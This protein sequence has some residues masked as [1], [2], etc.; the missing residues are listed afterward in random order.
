MCDVALGV[1]TSLRQGKVMRTHQFPRIWSKVVTSAALG[2][3]AMY[4]LDPN[5]GRRRRAI[6]RDKT[7]SSLTNITH[8]A[9]VSARDLSHRVQGLRAVARRLFKGRGAADDLVLI[10]RVRAKMGRVVSHP[11]AIQIGA[12]DGRITLSGPIVP[13]EVEP[14]LDAVRSVWGVSGIDDHL[15]VYDRPESIPALQGGGRRGATRSELM[16]EEWTPA[17][18]VAAVLGGGALAVCAMRQRGLTRVALA[19]MAVGLTARGAANM[20]LMHIAG[21]TRSR[22]TIELQRTIRVAAPRDMVYD[23]W[24]D[25]ENFPRFMSHVEEVREIG[26]DRTHW[27]VRGP[28]GSLFEWDA[29]VTRCIRPE[30][31]SWR[32]VPGTVVQHAGSLHFEDAEGGTRVSIKMSY[33][34]VAGLGHPIASLLGS[35]PKQQMEDDLARMKTFIEQGVP[36][37]DATA[38]ERESG[39]KTALH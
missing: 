5:K 24:T 36:P 32:T 25:C 34:A 27:V 31:L 7:R 17:L 4:V 14:L 16:Q 10:E 3:A 9:Q 30:V 33:N 29:V 22:R 21:F 39:S 20:P 28:A 38:R 11:H 1:I 2:A 37:H 26:D 19:T 15:V 6:F 12:R 23:L 8:L 18:R 13:G 35:D